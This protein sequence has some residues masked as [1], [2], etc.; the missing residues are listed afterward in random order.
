MAVKV[1][2]TVPGSE[3]D[4]AIPFQPVE[5]RVERALLELEVTAAPAIDLPEQLVSVHGLSG[6][7]RQQER[8]RVAF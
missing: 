3:H 2:G 6:K 1:G 7:K 4:L 8:L 5:S